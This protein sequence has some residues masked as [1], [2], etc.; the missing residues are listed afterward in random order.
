VDLLVD[1]SRP[2]GIQF[3]TTERLL[4]ERLGKPVE[5]CS[6]DVMRP[7]VRSRVEKDLIRV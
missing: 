2:L 1:L 3:L 6:W 5:F 4:A 7:H